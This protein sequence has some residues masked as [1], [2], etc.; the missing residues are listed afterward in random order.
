MVSSTN[1]VRRTVQERPVVVVGRPECCLAVVARHLLLRQGVNPAAL[2]V[3]Y[4]ADPAALVYALRAKDD[5]TKL[6]TDVAL[7]VVFV[8]GRLLGGLDRLI[9]M[10]IAEELVPLL[11]QAGALWL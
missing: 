9:T 5:N 10:H 4:D 6:V 8:G 2:E 7:P 11:R 1:E 3:S